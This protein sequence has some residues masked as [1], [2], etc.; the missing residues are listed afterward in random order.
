MLVEKHQSLCHSFLESY[1][2]EDNILSSLEIWIFWKGSFGN[3]IF[4]HFLQLI[5]IRNKIKCKKVKYQQLYHTFLSL[6]TFRNKL[7]CRRRSISS[8][9][10][11]F[12]GSYDNQG[13]ILMHEH[14]YQQLYYKSVDSCS[15]WE[16]TLRL[17]FFLEELYQ[18]YYAFFDSC[19]NWRQKLRLYHFLV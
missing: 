10:T 11:L 6:I 8:F 2:H 13:Q 16:Q 12:L 7:Y 3:N 9:I 19:S 4:T 5:L 1:I 15:N 18:L 14:N 17:H